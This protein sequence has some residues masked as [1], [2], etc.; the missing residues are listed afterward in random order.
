[1]VTSISRSAH[2]SPRLPNFFILG[3]PKAGTTALHVALS[4][5]PQIFLPAVKEPKYFLCNDLPPRRATQRGPGDAHSAREWVWRRARYE[6]LFADAPA[7][8]LIGESTP[9][10]LSDT[11]AQYRIRAAVPGARLLAVLRDPVDRAYSNWMHLWSDGLET[12]PTLR[13]AVAAEPERIAS[14][15][16]PFWHY[17]RLGLYGEQ[18]DHL[19][20]VFPREQILVLRYRDLVDSP[21]ETLDRVCRFL[22]VETGLLG[23]AAAQNARPYVSDDERRRWLS[24]VVRGGA[25]LGQFAPPRVWRGVESRVLRVLHA[26]GGARPPLDPADRQALAATFAADVRLLEQVTGGDF[27]DWLT[28][29]G[30]GAFARGPAGGRD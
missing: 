2:G 1:M 21:T 9:F 7:G 20:T 14:G 25:R 15:Y 16:A 13:E 10:Y 18:L 28:G 19:C 5:H 12:L 17:R 22:G 11:A 23:Y 27:G 24:R 3:A 30:R 26:G 6:A 4:M 8:A 29:S